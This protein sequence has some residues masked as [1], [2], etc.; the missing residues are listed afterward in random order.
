M[1]ELFNRIVS[2]L[3]AMLIGLLQLLGIDVNTD[4]FMP[5]M[6]IIGQ[7]AYG[8]QNPD[9][10]ILVKNTSLRFNVSE[11]DVALSG[12][13]REL[14]VESVQRKS[15]HT[16]VVE[17]S[18]TVT[19]DYSEGYVLV[20][21]EVLRAKTALQ[22]E[23][24]VDMSKIDPGI[25]GGDIPEEAKKLIQKKA[26][27]YI[28][29]G[30]K[31]IPYVGEIAAQLFDSKINELLGIKPAPSIK[32]VLTELEDIKNQIN[33][34]SFQIDK[35]SADILE[36]LYAESNFEDVNANLTTLR[37][38][39]A[40]VY[41]SIHGIGDNTPLG[42]TDDEKLIYEYVRSLRIAALLEFDGNT[43]S[44]LVTT[45]RDVST[46]VSGEQVS[47]KYEDSL[48]TKAFYYA[49]NDSVLGGEAALI[50][51]PYIN[52]VC[53]ILSHA[54]T[55]MSAVIAAKLYVC[56]H[57]SDITAKVKSLSELTDA[58]EELTDALG[59]LD[60]AFKGL[61]E[62]YKYD[63]KN[64]PAYHS[65]LLQLTSE[66]E[67]DKSVSIA[68]RHNNVL[69]KENPDSLISRYNKMVD[70]RWFSL[71]QNAGVESGSM[72]VS[73]YDLS[74]TL[75][76]VKPMEL[77]IDTSKTDEATQSMVKKVD[78]NLKAKLSKISSEEVDK[79]IEH[80]LANTN[81]VFVEK[82]AGVNVPVRTLRGILEDY[83]FAF[84]GTE[85]KVIFAFDSD[86]SYSNKL[87]SSYTASH[88]YKA[89][90]TAT[91]YN[92]GTEYGYNTALDCTGEI[93]TENTKY[94]SHSSSSTNG[95]I[96]LIRTS[97]EDCTFCYFAPAPIGLKTPEAFVDFLMSIAKGND[98]A[99]ETIELDTDIDL[100]NDR[101]EF[102]WSADMYASAFRGTFNGHMHTIT[103]LTDTT[104]YPGGGLFRTLGDGAKVSNLVFK[105]VNITS[106]GEKSG[107]GTLAGRV[108]GNAVVNSILVMDGSLSGHNMVGGIVG[109][110][111]DGSL[112][113]KDCSNSAEI[114]AT[115]NYAG[116]IVGGSTSKKSQNISI[117]TNAADVTAN[118]ASATGG[119]VGY[120][121][122]D[123]A[124]PTHYIDFCIN[125]GKITSKGGK[126]GGIIG[127]LDSDSNSHKIT[128]NNNYGEI[129]APE[130]YAGGIVAFS[131]GGGDFT[132]N[133]NSGNITSGKDG[134]G[135][136]AYNE[137]DAITFSGSAN[138]G[139]V[140]SSADAG[141][142][143]GYLGDNDHDKSYTAKNCRNSGVIIAKTSA[144]G[145]IGH[146]DSD[147]INQI[148]SDNENTG[149]ITST[150]YFAAGIV[151]YNE[152]G[153]DFTS[154]TNGGN[155]TS[156]KDGG[157]IVG[158]SEDDSVKFNGSVNT[159]NITATADAGGIV[160][161]AGSKDN[162]KAYTFIDCSNSGV[163]SSATTNAGGIAA[164]IKT[165]NKNHNFTGCT[166]DGKVT[167]KSTAGGIIGAMFGGGQITDCVNMADIK[168][169][170]DYAGGIVARIEDD[171]CTFSG[172]VNS[173]A[174]SSSKYQGPICGYDGYRKS[175]Y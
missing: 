7:Y 169:T 98:Y 78:S 96:G 43:P 30:I 120:L 55:V 27:A 63:L 94:Y 73:F 37:N 125:R 138:S 166:N 158:Y 129:K 109:E 87:V 86:Y 115:G 3:L 62:S 172:N 69:D 75:E 112:V 46:Y 14:T 53:D 26:K 82:E 31:K 8:D 9:I 22:A 159:G 160:G 72:D 168:G 165:D 48:F 41:N 116:G 85:G 92:C 108:T 155:I 60:N 122:N 61:K 88:D 34:I 16:L 103:G 143:A 81:H 104:S 136:V 64:N 49:C 84:P 156:G 164:V 106:T 162:D 35:A 167:G 66:E 99:N 171:K 111:T 89:S 124:D 1:I 157:G 42:E 121:A 139:N 50:I 12:A 76:S 126:T 118:N 25:I 33:G 71:I 6:E 79:V 163:I 2:A 51:S 114:T 40:G 113:I 68:A 47:I 28:T 97:V 80:I 65:F 58:P 100:S 105:D 95:Q 20:S 149:D 173:G 145:I 93:K 77:G 148:I 141:G 117:C 57:Y 175:T 144:G 59:Q 174:V 127:H 128:D 29:K 137:D 154:N 19:D 131:E 70:D 152:G 74:R 142:I 13:F 17:T 5:T 15:A 44:E 161:F 4:R 140:T 11:N 107:C 24:E 90:L 45:A 101:Y 38:D 102:V 56:E 151:A 10:E 110:V 150:T 130:G 135:I 32:D 18:G 67:N 133:T 153:G 146:L 36:A 23:T 54:D 132:G 123:S 91:G 119:I 21:G 170:G 147:G 39:V 134:A 52:E 83:G